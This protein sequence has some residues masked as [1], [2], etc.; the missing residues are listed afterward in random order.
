MRFRDLELGQYFMTEEYP[1]WILQREDYT[2][3]GY[4]GE[5]YSNALCGRVR[6]L[7]QENDEVEVV[8]TVT[9]HDCAAS[10]S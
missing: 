6:M 7:F 10:S 5:F 3:H 2:I 1:G 9:L 8:G 4:E